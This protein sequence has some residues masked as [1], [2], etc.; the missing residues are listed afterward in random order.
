M[1]NKIRRLITPTR[2]FQ[3]IIDNDCSWT[4]RSYNGKWVYY[5]Y[6]DIKAGYP[7][8]V[9]REIVD[10]YDTGYT[11]GYWAG[12]KTGKSIGNNEKED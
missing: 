4:G 7:V 3:W 1:L 10:I 11:E 6:G 2:K 9:S 8:K 5:W 12:F